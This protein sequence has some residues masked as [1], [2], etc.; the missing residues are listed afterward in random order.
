M[1]TYDGSADTFKMTYNIL[2]YENQ[3]LQDFF[4]LYTIIFEIRH[5]Y[6]VIVSF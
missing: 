6:L 3:S 5:A 2:D 4:L 1:I